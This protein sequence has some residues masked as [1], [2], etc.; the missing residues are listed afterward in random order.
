MSPILGIIASSKLK[1][2]GSFESI[3]TVTTT[4]G[5]ANIT[6]SSIPST[7]KHLQIRARLRS[8]GAGAVAF[9]IFRF[10]NYTETTS[11]HNLIGNGSSATAGGAASLDYMN[12]FLEIRN[13]VGLAN[14]YG[15]TICDIQN[16]TSSNFKTVRIFSGSE[17]TDRNGSLV[18]FSC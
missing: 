5:E 13:D 2:S 16:Y 3:A 11:F 15:V 10:N 1:V 6:L 12:G 8:V 9:D 17:N 18:L 7:Y 4:G 14:N